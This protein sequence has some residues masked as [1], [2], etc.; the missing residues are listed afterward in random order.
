MKRLLTMFLILTLV[1]SFS[2]AQGATES[3]K[4]EEKAVEAEATVE[5][6]TAEEVK[7]DNL[8]YAYVPSSWEFPCVW[9]WENATGKGA[10][11]SWPGE[12]M[13]KDFNNEGWWYIY[14]PSDMDTVIIN[15]NDGSI[16]TDSIAVS[17]NT[18]IKVSEDKS[19]VKMPTQ[20]TSGDLPENT[21]RYY[22]YAKVDGS[23]ENPCIWAWKN[24][25]GKGAYPVWPGMNM[26]ASS[27]GWYSALVP[28]WCDSVI[29][30]ANGGTVQTADI[31]DLDPADM[32][33]EVLADGSFELTYVDPTIPQVEDITVY[34]KVPEDWNEPCLWAW[35][36]PEGT[37]AYVSWPGEK[38]EKCD[39]GWYKITTKGWINSV[40]INANGGTVQTADLRVESGK[41]VYVTVN[42][43]N[44]ATFS[45]EK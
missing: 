20:L 40:I 25:G 45:Y 6:G 15:A 35:Q 14:L 32:W 11:A 21:D 24:E 34:A 10:F 13:A 33:I 5:V 9:A 44:D 26:K 31:K 39:D 30:N 28:E 19:A 42:S 18:W 36:H 16:Q 38:M 27:N 41:D 22:V 37:N 17:G 43:A 3:V 29:I 23:W 4:S 1:L 8:I 2:F 7:E 12:M